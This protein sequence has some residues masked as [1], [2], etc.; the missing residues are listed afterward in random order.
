MVVIIEGADALGKSTQINELVKAA[1][2]RDIVPHILHYSNVKAF[3]KNK[4]MI[5]NF[6]VSEYDSIFKFMEEYA[7]TSD[8]LF[9]FD[10]CHLSEYVYSPMYRGYDGYYIFASERRI[11]PTKDYVK[12]VL[13]TDTAENVIERD[14]KRGDGLSFSLDV[15]KKRE[16]LQKFEEAFEESSIEKKKL[17]T[18]GKR[19]IGDISKELIDF[20]F[21]EDDYDI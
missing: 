9:I 14:K 16:E 1:Q 11:V 13:F 10:R 2:E 8:D 20:V 6:S 3:G 21:E 12:L 15:D 5:R 4:D 7:M 18:V 19:S 17:I